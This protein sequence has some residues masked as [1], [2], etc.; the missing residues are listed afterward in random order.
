M[1]AF[2]GRG[3]AALAC[4]EVIQPLEF[5][6]KSEECQLIDLGKSPKI[7]RP[8]A[9]LPTPAGPK[10]ATPEMEVHAMSFDGH[11]AMMGDSGKP[12]LERPSTLDL[13]PYDVLHAFLSRWG[14]PSDADV[15]LWCHALDADAEAIL[16]VCGRWLRI[17]DQKPTPKQLVA[18]L[19]P[20]TMQSICEQ[21]AIE[22]GLTADEIK[23]ATRQA[24]IAQPRQKA[25]RQMRDAGY[26]ASQIARFFG[27]D[28][29]TV[30][31]GIKAAEK[32]T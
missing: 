22:S 11:Y 29:T 13:Y 20:N 18:L 9:V 32:R 8:D 30:M 14:D 31:H 12:E 27:L 17:S 2:A 5:C 15:L 28:H 19:R 1:G 24:R 21:V 6:A 7:E 3:D 23:I 16:A 10:T 4:S 25:M 26:G